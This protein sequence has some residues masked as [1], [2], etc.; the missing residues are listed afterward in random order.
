MEMVGNIKEI[1]EA[2][3][4]AESGGLITEEEAKR[5]V[6]KYLGV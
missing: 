5:L 2:I 3:I 1:I 4:L 6:K